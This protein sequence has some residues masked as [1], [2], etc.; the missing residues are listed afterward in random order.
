MITAPALIY[1][2]KDRILASDE[3]ENNIILQI[4]FQI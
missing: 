3:G 1:G 4:A 2:D